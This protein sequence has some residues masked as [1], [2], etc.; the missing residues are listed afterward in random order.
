M[1]KLDI[2]TTQS[3]NTKSE[4]KGFALYLEGKKV[5]ENI[6]DYRPI[7]EEKVRIEELLV[8]LGFKLKITE[9]PKKIIDSNYGIFPDNLDELKSFSYE[10]AEE[11][12]PGDDYNFD[13]VYFPEELDEDDSV[14]YNNDYDLSEFDHASDSDWLNIE[15]H[16]PENDDLDDWE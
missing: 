10:E 13:D 1:K 12:L 8:A 5:W 7:K 9:V 6:D 16:Y 2:I 3:L 11:I 14:A 15:D 4:N